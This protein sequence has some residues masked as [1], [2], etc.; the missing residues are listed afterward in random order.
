MIRIVWEPFPRVVGTVEAVPALH[1]SVEH[2][3]LCADCGARAA[4]PDGRAVTCR[5]C[6]W[7]TQPGS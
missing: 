4:T 3:L 5:A 1:A 7:S 6:G 2:G